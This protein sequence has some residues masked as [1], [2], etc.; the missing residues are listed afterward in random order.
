MKCCLGKGLP[1]VFYLLENFLTKCF[2]DESDQGGCAIYVL[3]RRT[4]K[5]IKA[6]ADGSINGVL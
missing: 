2:V 6:G 1:V 3:C 4:R 5:V